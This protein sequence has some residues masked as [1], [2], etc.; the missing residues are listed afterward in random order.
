[1]RWGRPLGNTTQSVYISMTLT[2]SGGYTTTDW[3]TSDPV[4]N[5]TTIDAADGGRVLRVS[6]PFPAPVEIANLILQ[7]GLITGTGSSIQ[8]DGGAIHSFYALTLTNVSVL[9]S[10]AASGQGGGLYTGSTLYLTNTHFI[11]NTSSDIGGGARASEATTAVN[12]RFEK[13]QTGGSGGGLN[14]SGSLTLT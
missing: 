9:S 4:A 5:P 11:N 13:N 12:S 8:S 14:V 10:T 7:R 1:M 3:T 6:A 2:L